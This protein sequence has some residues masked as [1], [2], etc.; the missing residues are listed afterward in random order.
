MPWIKT[1]LRVW[2]DVHLH[3]RTGMHRKSQEAASALD[4]D[5]VKRDAIITSPLSAKQPTLPAE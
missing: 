3:W 1:F 4:D 5:D 2:F